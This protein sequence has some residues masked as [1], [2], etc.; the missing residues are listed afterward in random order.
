MGKRIISALE[1]AFYD[2]PNITET[3]DLEAEN[4]SEGENKRLGESSLIRIICLDLF[5]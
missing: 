4:V 3:R 5:Q 2:T 1:A